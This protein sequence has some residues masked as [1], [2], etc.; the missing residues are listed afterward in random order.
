MEIP[1]D[2]DNLLNYYFTI[3]YLLFYYSILFPV[4][5][6]IE[7]AMG[8]V[9]VQKE[10]D[11]LF[12]LEGNRTAFVSK[13]VDNLKTDTDK[14]KLGPWTCHHQQNSST[15]DIPPQ[16]SFLRHIPPASSVSFRVIGPPRAGE[17]RLLSGG[18]E[19]A[20][21]VCRD[22][23]RQNPC[24]GWI[25]LCSKTSPLTPCFLTRL[26]KTKVMFKMHTMLEFVLDVFLCLF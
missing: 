20:D 25:R 2:F 8:C 13:H 19:L 16:V 22:L 14:G 1:F 7:S 21:G 24:E 23:K 18:H 6:I 17:E 12:F 26:N 15:A 11:D 9:E 3:Y 10:T 4:I 5:R